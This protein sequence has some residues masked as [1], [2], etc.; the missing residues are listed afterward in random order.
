VRDWLDDE[1]HRETLG[2]GE[3]E[4]SRAVTGSGT[5]AQKLLERWLEFVLNAETRQL[6]GSLGH[7]W[8]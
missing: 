2:P 1:G 6:K 7:E 4:L 3:C 8:K 5:S